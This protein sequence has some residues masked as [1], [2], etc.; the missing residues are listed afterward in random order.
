MNSSTPAQYNSMLLIQ[1]KG[2]FP[3]NNSLSQFF[4]KGETRLG[5]RKRSRNYNRNSKKLDRYK[6]LL[7]MVKSE[8]K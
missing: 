7:L 3:K 6:I 2:I 5:I 8:T 4:L 1:S